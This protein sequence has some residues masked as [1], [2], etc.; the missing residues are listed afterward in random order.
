MKKKNNPELSSVETDTTCRWSSEAIRAQLSRILGHAEFQATDKMHDFLRFVV[1]ETLAGRSQH[2]KGFTIAVEVYGRDTDF[3]AAHDPVVRIQAGRL[4][5]A[6]E[7][8]YLVSGGRTRSESK[9]RKEATFRYSLTALVASLFQTA[10]AL[11]Q[12]RKGR[13]H[14]GQPY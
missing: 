7:R 3:D 10:W 6:M 1:E 2:I 14:R 12:R 5:R 8:Y 11:C 13:R 9:F 4:R